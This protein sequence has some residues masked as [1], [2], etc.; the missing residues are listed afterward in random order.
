MASQADIKLAEAF[1]PYSTQQ[2]L[3]EAKRRLACLKM[4]EKRVVLIGP[5]GSGKGSQA[6]RLKTQ[7]C[8]CHLATGDMLRAAVQA[9]SEMGKKAKAVMD[10][11]ELVSDDIVVGIIGDAIKQPSCSKGF[12]L[13]GFPR[14]V[15]QAQ[16]L[17]EMLAARGVKVDKVVNMALDDEVLIERI[18]GRLVH[19]SSG[20]SY[21][22]KFNPPKHNMTDDLTGEPLIHR[23]DDNEE[24]LRKRLQAFHAQT[25][26]CIDFYAKQGKV[27]NIDA[28]QSFERVWSEIDAAVNQ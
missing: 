21:H 23:S 7:N 4:P 18:T 13:D 24:T 3:A 27:A 6:P 26:P 17:D 12:I 20:R 14:T 16:K 1:E 22:T 25:M 5:P 19:P 28:D 10:R 8:L 11:G 9:G 2:I 15:V